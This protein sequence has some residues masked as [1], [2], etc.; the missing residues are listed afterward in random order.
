[1]RVTQSML[2]S[3]MLRNLNT[4]YGKMSKLQEQM[5][6]GKVINRPSDDPVIAVKGMGYR[7]DLDKNEQYQ[8]NMREAHTWLDST[9]ESLD[10]V[11]STLHRIKELIIQAA[12]D[13]NTTEDRQKISTE[14]AQIKEQLRDIAN[15]KVGESYIF[16]GTHTNSPLYTKDPLTTNPTTGQNVA[17]T[18]TGAAKP[19]EVNVFDG[20][21]MPI[22]IR[23]DEYF[24]EVDDFM[25]RIESILQSPATSEKISSELGVTV[26]NGAGTVLALDGI[27]EK[28]LTLRAGVGARQNR[29]ELMENRLEM[30]EVNVTK[31]LSLNEDTDYAKAI[32]DMATTESIHQAAL[33]VG[34]KIIQQTLVDFIR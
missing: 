22:N 16:S 33:S 18:T 32:T 25:A 9:D 21:S 15:T 30:Q 34:A 28:T 14:I 2:S 24:K 13:T 17:I 10:Q 5:N 8:R 1:M 29:V 6:S 19:I 31:Q 7:V 12:N 26:T 4:S 23:G 11:G 27:Y 3:N 20:I